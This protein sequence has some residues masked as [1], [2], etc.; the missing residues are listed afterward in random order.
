MV[1]SSMVAGPVQ[2]VRHRGCRHR[3]SR[4]QSDD[5]FSRT[6]RHVWTPVMRRYLGSC[7]EAPFSFHEILRCDPGHGGRHHHTRGRLTLLYS[8]GH[9]FQAR[10]LF[11]GEERAVLERSATQGMQPVDIVFGQLSIYKIELID[12]RKKLLRGEPSFTAATLCESRPRP[13]GRPRPR[14]PGSPIFGRC[15]LLPAPPSAVAH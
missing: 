8:A 10:D 3:A 15:S 2:H 12:F 1:L 4:A 13:K 9:G 6:Q 14:P 7:L 5:A 11:T